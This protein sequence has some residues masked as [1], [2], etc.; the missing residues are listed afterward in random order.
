MKYA[1]IKGKECE[2]FEAET[3]YELASRD[4]PQAVPCVDCGSEA[5]WAEA[6]YVPGHRVCNDCGS[7]Y[8][9]QPAG[10]SQAGHRHD[11]YVTRYL[12]TRAVFSVA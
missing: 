12:V 1:I 2:R 4:Y 7:H 11:A 5:A 8:S 9:C 3:L 10:P 6:G